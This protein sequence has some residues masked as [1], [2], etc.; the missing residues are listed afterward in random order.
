MKSDLHAQA[1]TPVAQ[2]FQRDYKE[3]REAHLSQSVL[4]V[5]FLFIGLFTFLFVPKTQYKMAFKYWLVM[6][7]I[8]TVLITIISR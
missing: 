4:I 3:I 1:L 7:F 8:K 2:V 5:L 6:V